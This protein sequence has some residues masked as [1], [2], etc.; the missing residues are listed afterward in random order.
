M[1]ILFAVDEVG[2]VAQPD[3]V[4]G[5]ASSG[6][7]ARHTFAAST[8]RYHDLSIAV[9]PWA[10]PAAQVQAFHLPAAAAA[11]VT[12][13]A[14]DA[15]A[16][17][18]ASR[19]FVASVDA[20]G[21]VNCAVIS[22]LCVHSNGTHTECA[23]HALPGAVTLAHVAPLLSLLPALLLSAAPA[24]L[25]AACAEEYP[26]GDPV[27]DRV[28]SASL[29]EEAFERL[30]AARAAAGAGGGG[31]GDV[32]RARRVLRGFL[33]RGALVV[34]TLPNAAAKRSAQYGGTS[35]PY[36]TAC[37]MRWALL[38]GCEHVVMDLPS[39][40]REQDRGLLI[41]H[42]TWWGL[43]PAGDAAADRAARACARTITELAFAEDAAADGA[44]L[45]DL[46]VAPFDMDAAPS[47][48]LLYP[49]SER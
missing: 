5:R 23:G 33:R 32:E 41:A 17:P 46:Q 30:A 25:G 1:E 40:D 9:T 37:A 16:A 28:I 48:P 22:S 4:P 6:G 12:V 21:S 2:E 11:P 20:G 18:E 35:P 7:A 39:A 45:L 43:P 27:A 36:F 42:R 29:L 10:P 34:R 13:P 38:R 47:R 49:V 3:A 31:G 19:G 15:P 24:P 8:A 14:A 44:Y 26:P